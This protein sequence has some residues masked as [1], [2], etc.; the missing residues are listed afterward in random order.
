MKD[1]AHNIPA[2]GKIGLLGVIFTLVGF[3]V[4]ASIYILPGQLFAIA[5]P[6]M[7]ASMA[8]ASIPAL[9][10]CL[11]AAQIGTAYQGS[12]ANYLAVNDLLSPLWGFLTVWAIIGS[13][14]VTLAL[15][16]YGFADYVSTLLPASIPH[17]QLIA[18]SVIALFCGLNFLGAKGAAWFQVAIVVGLKSSLLLFAIIGLAHIE[19]SHFIPFTPNGTTGML[20]AVVPACFSFLGFSLIVDV[21]EEI[22]EPAHIIPRALA[23][24]FAIIMFTYLAVALVV[25]GTLPA[26]VLTT[27]STP[28]DD[29]AKAFLP[30]WA[31]LIMAIGAV[32]A[33]TTSINGVLL[34]VSRD[35]VAIAREAWLPRVFAK[36]AGRNAVPV[37]AISLVGSLAALAV[38]TGASIEKFAVTVVTGSLVGQI[39]IM[40]ACWRMPAKLGDRYGTLPFRMHPIILRTICLFT[41]ASSV[42]LIIASVMGSWMPAAAA[43]AYFVAGYGWYM[44]R[45]DHA[46]V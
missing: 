45:R 7:V 11:L 9:C 1:Q 43:V 32:M 16:A 38:M 4:G 18:V 34:L 40:A 26:D 42:I 13:C 35:V 37:N 12:G 41:G 25:I 36:L 29:A 23:W 28:I 5:G 30:S 24:S 46:A 14:V 8:I 22:R 17:R 2:A 31:I 44:V 15:L 21:S 39:L 3:V 20:I 6:S 19:P 10:S 33:A 27:S